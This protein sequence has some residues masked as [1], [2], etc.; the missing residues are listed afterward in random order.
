LDSLNEL[1]Y[2]LNG[3]VA[4]GGIINELVPVDTSSPGQVAEFHYVHQWCKLV[5]QVKAAVIGDQAN[6]RT[7]LGPNR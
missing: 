2:R 4:H 7:D 5:L 3:Y 6:F 1:S